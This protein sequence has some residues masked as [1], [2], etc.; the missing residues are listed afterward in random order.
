[1]YIIGR[2]RKAR[3]V[4]MGKFLIVM[5]LQVNF[6]RPMNHTIDHT[7]HRP[8]HIP[9]YKGVVYMYIMVHANTIFVIENK[10]Y[11]IWMS[12]LQRYLIMRNL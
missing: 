2:L 5:T 4:G 3:E 1:M 10:S 9:M 11:G 8:L 6:C 7:Y 12:L